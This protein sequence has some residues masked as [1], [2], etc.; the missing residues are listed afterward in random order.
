MTFGGGKQ[1]KAGAE[2]EAGEERD[3]LLQ[4]DRL[5]DIH[6]IFIDRLSKIKNDRTI[7]ESDLQSV[8]F[9][10]G[11][12]LCQVLLWYAPTPAWFAS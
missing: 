11:D 8:P 5:M 9:W 6:F 4:T 12:R 3:S 2:R 10:K 7:R 1:R